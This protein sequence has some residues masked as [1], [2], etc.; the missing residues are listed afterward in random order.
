MEGLQQLKN[1]FDYFAAAEK[2]LQLCTLS[3]QQKQKHE[4]MDL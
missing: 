2:Q 4:I 1:Y 3:S